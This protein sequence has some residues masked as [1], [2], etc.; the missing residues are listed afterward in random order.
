MLAKKHRLNL[1]LQQNANIFIRG[2]SLFLSSQY[3]LAYL[4]SNQSDF[5]ISCLTSKASLSK[6]TLRNKFRRFLY[7]LVE[8]EFQNCNFS[9]NMAYDLVIILKRNFPLDKELLEKDFVILAKQ[10]QKNIKF[11]S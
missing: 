3:F 6:S 5:K 4:R 7:S 8:K 2:N 11:K 10:I 1:S 9:P